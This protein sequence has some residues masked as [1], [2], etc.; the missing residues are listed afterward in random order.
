M[1][2][3]SFTFLYLFL[4]VSLAVY[5]LFPQRMRYGVLLGISLVFFL[6]GDPVSLLFL[7]VSATVD[8]GLGLLMEHFDEQNPRRRAIMVVM[9]AKNLLFFFGVSCFCQLH[10]L[11]TPLGLAVCTLLG[12]GYAVDIYNGEALYE[13]NWGK[14]LLAHIL[15][16]K[17]PAGPLVR[18]RSLCEQFSPK[19]AD[20][21]QM[22][23]SIC[24]LIQGAA[25]T[26]HSR[27]AN[28]TAVYR[29]FGLFPVGTFGFF[30]VADAFV[31]RH[32]PVFHPVRLLRH[33]P[34]PGRDVRRGAS[35]EF[36][37][38][39][40]VRSVTDF[41]GRFNISVTAYLKTYIYHPLAKTPAALPPPPSIL[42]WSRCCGVSGSV[43]AS[44]IFCGGF[45][46]SC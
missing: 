18:Y 21:A 13:H 4:P 29:P 20:L 45:I 43:F 26:G 31:R 5:Y 46:L 16:M 9:V 28:P 10:G 35:T 36:L 3:A 41:V 39:V 25:K 34:R 23:E 11:Q 17:L 19:K 44:T 1:P 38:P 24:L 40:S 8:Y 12:T 27:R 30:S 6:L 2:L 7:S 32:E 14:F 42:D 15:F 33:G 37:L 22:S